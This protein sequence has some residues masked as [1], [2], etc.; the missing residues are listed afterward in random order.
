MAKSCHIC[1]KF[2]PLLFSISKNDNFSVVS[3]KNNTKF[4]S[5]QLIIIP[6]EAR[7]WEELL[8]YARK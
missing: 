2:I 5:V 4:C 3:R 1:H 6:R 7:D 8:N